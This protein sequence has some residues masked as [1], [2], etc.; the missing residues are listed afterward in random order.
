MNSSQ[1]LSY[2]PVLW[3]IL[4]LVLVA[5]LIW[6]LNLQR[7]SAALER[8]LESLLGDLSDEG[9]ARM[10]ADYLGT[11][12]DTAASVQQMRAEHDELVRTM[13]SVIRHVGLVRFSPFHDTGGDQSFAL[14]LLV[15]ERSGVVVT[16]LHARTDSRLYAKPVERGSSA[17]SLTPE[18][19]HAMAIALGQSPVPSGR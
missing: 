10:L 9:T 16:G 5:V 7:R 2:G 3:A 13:P 14:A 6:T 12:R 19:R 11:V 1:M 8:R 15:G 17:Y 18:E 4:V